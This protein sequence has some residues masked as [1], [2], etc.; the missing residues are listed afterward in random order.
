MIKL[1]GFIYDVIGWLASIGFRQKKSNTVLVIRVDEIGDYVLWRK[2]LQPILNNPNN[3]N[4][5]FYFCGNSSF[6]QLFQLEYSHSFLKEFWVDKN[7]FKTNMR[8]RYKFLKQLY[9]L[10]VEVVVNPTYSRAKRVDDSMVKACK[11]NLAIA[12]HR[13]SENYFSYEENFDKNLYHQL[14]NIGQKSIFEFYRNQLFCQVLLQ[15]EIKNL[16]SNTLF[17]NVV[18]P[19]IQH[20]NL[21]Q[22]YFV[23][24]PGSRSTSRI[25]ATDNFVALSNFYFAKTN[26]VAIVCGSKNDEGYC[27]AFT[28]AYKN[29]V[30]NICGK[31][32]LPQMLAVLQ[33]A[34]FLFS[35]DTGSVHLAAAVGCPVLGIYNG[36]Q[37]GRFA[38]YPKE[39][40]STFYALYPQDILE[41]LQ[42][43]TLVATKYQYVI[44]KN[45]NSV[46][47]QQAINKLETVI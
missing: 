15:T 29:S 17:S 16:P 26:Y 34:K 44:S 30:I 31:T 5:Q 25:W 13:N 24:F 39:I 11:A 37:F 38:P 45:Y 9:K 41:E 6:K 36:G 33:Q 46:T 21:P 43:E 18:L 1:K 7:L 35:V 20:L 8:Y 42:N 27:Q 3:A 12:M 40:S 19:N 10:G 2:F 47:S 22:N 28:E 4:T 14:I 23:V 32:N